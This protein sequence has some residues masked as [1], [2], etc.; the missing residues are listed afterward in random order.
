MSMPSASA[1]VIAAKYPANILE[2]TVNTFG[3]LISRRYSL[4][5]WPT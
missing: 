1:T 3:S 2:G 5:R 4:R